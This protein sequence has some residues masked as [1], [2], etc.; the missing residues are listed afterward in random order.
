MRLVCRGG[1]SGSDEVSYSI[2]WYQGLSLSN[3]DSKPNG[4]LP[5]GAIGGLPFSLP[6]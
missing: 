3:S 5:S 2:P 4:I 1:A 6:C